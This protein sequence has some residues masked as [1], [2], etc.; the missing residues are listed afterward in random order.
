MG[1]TLG[2]GMMFLLT[3]RA[4]GWDAKALSFVA[5]YSMLGARD[6]S[7]AATFGEAMQRGNWDKVTRLRTDPHDPEPACWCHWGPSV[8]HCLSA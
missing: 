8:T 2:K 6:A 4:D 7:L 1:P 3:R 5:I